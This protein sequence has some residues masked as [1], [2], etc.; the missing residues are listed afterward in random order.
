MIYEGWLCRTGQ[1]AL[2]FKYGT[3]TAP[4]NEWQTG[5]STASLLVSFTEASWPITERLELVAYAGPK[6]ISLKVSWKLMEMVLQNS[7][8]SV[9]R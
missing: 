8:C 2:R 6:G 1:G 9:V 3:V 7:F 5:K 4:Y